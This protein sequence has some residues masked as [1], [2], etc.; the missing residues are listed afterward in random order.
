ML[1]GTD[2]DPVLLGMG[3]LGSR[4]TIIDPLP[5]PGSG[6]AQGVLRRGSSDYRHRRMRV[7]EAAMMIRVSATAVSCS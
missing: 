7:A 3:D 5:Y 4:L 2:C 6:P 1:L